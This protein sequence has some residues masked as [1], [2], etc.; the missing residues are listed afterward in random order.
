[1]T[2]HSDDLVKKGDELRLSYAGDNGAPE[3]AENV[4]VKDDGTIEPLSV[5]ATK[6][7]PMQVAGKT[8]NEIEEELRKTAAETPAPTPVQPVRVS[9]LDLDGGRRAGADQAFGA[10]G[11]G[12]TTPAGGNALADQQRAT[13]GPVA[14]GAAVLPAT[15]PAL[16]SDADNLIDVVIVV[17]KESSVGPAA[18]APATPHTPV[19]APPASPA[20][21]TQPS[22]LRE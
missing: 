3:Q 21:A 20:P 6:G 19:I 10:A 1:S 15:H 13:T 4:K 14:E 2:T 18:A 9:R 8:L 17:Q 22:P 11:K 16:A 5:A 7:K 12:G